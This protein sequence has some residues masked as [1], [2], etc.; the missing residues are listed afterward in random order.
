MH[1]EELGFIEHSEKSDVFLVVFLV[2]LLAVIDLLVVVVPRSHHGRRGFILHFIRHNLVKGSLKHSRCEL[3]NLPLLTSSSEN[4]NSSSSSS[5]NS[6]SSSSSSE[7]SN[8]SSSSSAAPSSSSSSACSSSSS[9]SPN[10]ITPLP[11]EPLRLANLFANLQ[12]VEL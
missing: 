11:L 6:N 4:S 9:S 2:V 1:E 8:S 5:E 7:N 12:T 10:T 3:G